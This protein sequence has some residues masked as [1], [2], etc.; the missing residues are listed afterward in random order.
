MAS[1]KLSFADKA[2]STLCESEVVVSGD[3]CADLFVEKI[4]DGGWQ[5]ASRSE[6]LNI[7]RCSADSNPVCKTRV[8]G[9]GKNKALKGVV[10]KDQ[11]SFIDKVYYGQTT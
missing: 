1:A 4:G 3:P 6:S 2:M 9:V 8:N 11:L 10:N 5:E 7:S